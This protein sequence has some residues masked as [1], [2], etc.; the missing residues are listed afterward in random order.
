[1]RSVSQ[2]EPGG[3]A[4]GRRASPAR[5]SIH[6]M[7]LLQ[8]A[9]RASEKGPS[10]VGHEIP[11]YETAIPEN[12]ELTTFGANETAAESGIVGGTKID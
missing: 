8:A 9:H 12:E 1:M 11:L 3:G 5:N 7:A 10:P 6:K 4:G 2:Q